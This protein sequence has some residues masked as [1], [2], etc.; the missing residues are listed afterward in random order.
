VLGSLAALCA[1]AT[2]AAAAMACTLPHSSMGLPSLLGLMLQHWTWA[3]RG[4]MAVMTAANAAG[5]QASAAVVGVVAGQPGLP[6]ALLQRMLHRDAEDD[7]DC[8]ASLVG[9]AILQVRLWVW[10]PCCARLGIS[11]ACCLHSIL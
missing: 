9:A 11:T 5:P 6:G 2:A 10:N 7:A 1:N 8:A 3:A 4:C